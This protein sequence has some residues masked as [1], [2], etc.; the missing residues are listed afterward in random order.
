MSLNNLSLAVIGILVGLLFL[1]I[2]PMVECENLA[3]SPMTLQCPDGAPV[4]PIWPT[5]SVLIAGLGVGSWLYRNR[6]Q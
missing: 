5:M 6:K 3:G 2:G 1:A 4:S